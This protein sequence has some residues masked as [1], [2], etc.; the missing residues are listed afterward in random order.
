[1]SSPLLHSISRY[2][3]HE[4]NI[5]SFN[6]DGAKLQIIFFSCKKI[7]IFFQIRVQMDE[8]D[9]MTFVLLRWNEKGQMQQIR[10]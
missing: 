2:T 5:I 10:N 8:V 6:E 9:D 1:M 3:A 4:V 7:L